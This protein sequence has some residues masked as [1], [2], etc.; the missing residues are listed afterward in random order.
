MTIEKGRRFAFVFS[1][2]HYTWFLFVECAK[3]EVDL[4]WYTNRPDFFEDFI[5]MDIYGVDYG[6][7][8][9]RVTYGL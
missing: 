3:N 7:V 5:L 9:G 6:E 8:T 2:R 4:E 1:V